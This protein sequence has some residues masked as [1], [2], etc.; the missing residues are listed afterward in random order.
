MAPTSVPYSPDAPLLYTADDDIYAIPWGEAWGDQVDTELGFLFVLLSSL[1]LVLA[2]LGVSSEWYVF[3]LDGD[4]PAASDDSADV[5]YSWFDVTTTLLVSLSSHLFPYPDTRSL[6]TKILGLSIG[7]AV[8]AAGVVASAA[9]S[10]AAR[11][12][13]RRSRARSAA[14]LSALLATATVA[15]AIGALLTFRAEFS[16]VTSDNSICPHLQPRGGDPDEAKSSLFC[17]SFFG[18]THT[19]EASATW[20]PGLAFWASAFVASTAFLSML[21]GLWW[22]TPRGA[23]AATALAILSVMGALIAATDD[24]Y[25]YEVVPHLPD[26]GESAIL[27]A[28]NQTRFRSSVVMYSEEMAHPRSEL[29]ATMRLLVQVF[30]LQLGGTVISLLAC[31]F[32]WL[33]Y[34]RVLN[35]HSGFLGAHSVI[36]AQSAQLLSIVLS[37]IGLAYFAIEYPS[38]SRSDGSCT[39]SPNTANTAHPEASPL[40]GC[41]FLGSATLGAR[42]SLHLPE[43]N[44]T[45]GPGLGFWV[46]AAGTL[47]QLGALIM[48]T[49]RRR[50]ARSR[51]A[52]SLLIASLG[53]SPP[54]RPILTSYSKPR[55]YV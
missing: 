7:A 53:T 9:A 49:L 21:V 44:L 51:S 36:L 6:M 48:L 35:L 20:G 29:P 13:L 26:P 43:R 24:W 15:T 45:W 27:I 31:S 55:A 5:L 40:P 12:S 32:C 22:D 3:R 2:S 8:L 41:S 17:A 4:V 37:G 11:L 30:G 33:A 10:F 34:V 18:E 47:F 19:P 28:A 1:A 16:A 50:R 23:F 38:A 42:P 39:S 25:V 46:A 52:R 54:R 14:V